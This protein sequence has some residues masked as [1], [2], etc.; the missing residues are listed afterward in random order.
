[1]RVLDLCISV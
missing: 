1:M